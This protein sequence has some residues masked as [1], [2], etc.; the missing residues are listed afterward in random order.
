[1]YNFFF[2]KPPDASHYTK[3]VAVLSWKKTKEKYTN[4][5]SYKAAKGRIT[6]AEIILC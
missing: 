4:L 2:L 5:A 6:R 3:G 1:M